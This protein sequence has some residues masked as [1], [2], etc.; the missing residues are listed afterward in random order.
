MLKNF[1]KM[2]LRSLRR[3]K[4]YALINIVGLSIAIACAIVAYIN[5][6]YAQK[7]DAFHKN[8]P[9]IYRVF[10]IRHLNR[11]DVQYGIAPVPLGPALSR[12]IAGI[13]N[14]VRL[15]WTNAIVRNHD[16]VF[17]E[18]ILCADNGFFSMF[19]FPLKSGTADLKN[20]SQVVISEEY[21][22]K[23]FGAGN[24]I[25]KTLTCLIAD[26]QR[27]LTVSG[28]VQ[29]FPSNSSITF[30]L[31][32]S[33]D[34]LFD[35]GINK[36]DD[37]SFWSGVLFVQVRDMGVLPALNRQLICCL[38]PAASANPKMPLSGF[39]IMPLAMVSRHN[40]N[41]R[42]NELVSGTP[43]SHVV[44]VAGMGLLLLLLACFN[45]INIA[46]AFSD[47]R[48]KEI[49]VRKVLGSNRFQ[50]IMQFIGE[51]I[52]LCLTAMAGGLVLTKLA[53]PAFNR[54]YPFVQLSLNLGKDW[55]LIAFLFVLLFVT[56]IIASLYP[57]MVITAPQPVSV[58]RGRFKTRKVSLT[59]RI[60]L[61]FQFTLSIIM[62]IG[63]IAFAKNAEF[64][65]KF[66]YGFQKNGI[67]S[68]PL[69]S[70]ASFAA[71]KSEMEKDPGIETIS[72]CQTHIYYIGSSR[73]IRSGGRETEV[74]LFSVGFNFPETMG[75]RLLQG[76]FFQ[77]H[78]AADLQEAVVVNAML[79]KEMNWTAALGQVLSLEGKSYRVIGVIDDVY[80]GGP[81]VPAVPILFRMAKPEEF[82]WLQARVRPDAQER[83]LASIGS[84]WQ[85]LFPKQP[86]QSLFQPPRLEAAI[87]LNQ[88][89]KTNFDA[90]GFIAIVLSAIG[91]FAL[92]S[93]HIAARTKELGIRKVLGAKIGQLLF[94]TQRR[95]VTPIVIAFVLGD[96]GGYFLIRSLM[97]SIFAYHADI[98]LT[99]LLLA[100]FLVATLAL[101]A[102]STRIWRAARA[103][104]VES[105]RYE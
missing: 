81:W 23:Y 19:T 35:V 25:G 57:A 73:N 88:N 63:S 71:L 65:K 66:D 29:K 37:W 82:V 1:L 20:R 22:N 87:R 21:A 90:I 33:N 13:V 61:S 36:A 78:S 27:E 102:V 104:P 101:A 34:L 8:G 60:L 72:G 26:A 53:L 47:Q 59:M 97:G 86:F 64:S 4:A 83:M 100:N 95:F 99:S 58:L 12:N 49:G 5:Y 44:G 6:D 48:A 62:V 52:C 10:S 40:E 92:V 91:F 105:L 17:S 7:Y 84:T 55:K 75:L 67:V 80:R 50:L 43:I 56:G 24:P 11:Q 15:E 32:A 70:S 93:L 28:V 16:R 39:G 18:H 31:L 74:Q 96:I 2:S 46:I 76:R 42:S 77:E 103:N 3:N 68:L 9:S 98:T 85:R 94:L 69:P 54:L 45:F 30:D 89:I 38:Q 41:L 14:S 79:A 51:N